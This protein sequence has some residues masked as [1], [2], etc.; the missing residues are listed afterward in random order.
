VPEILGLF[1]VLKENLTSGRFTRDEPAMPCKPCLVE[2][3]SGW[4]IA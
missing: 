4:L 2:E 1:L 3:K